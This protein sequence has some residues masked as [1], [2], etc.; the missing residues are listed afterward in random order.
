MIPIT[1]GVGFGPFC[2]GGNLWILDLLKCVAV[3]KKY[4]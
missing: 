2:F 3:K 1:F 4:T